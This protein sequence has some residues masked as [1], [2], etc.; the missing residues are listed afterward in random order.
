MSRFYAPHEKVHV[1]RKEIYING[2][3][4]HHII[5]VMRLKKDDKVIVFDG[6]GCEYEGSIKRIDNHDK[7]V[8]VNIANIRKP[9][10]D[11]KTTFHLAQAIPKKNRMDYVVEKATE[12]GVDQII[13]V[14]SDR[15]VV[16]PDKSS[17]AKKVT[18][19]QK[20]A[21][22]TAKQCGRS[23]IPQISGIT[24]YSDIVGIIDNY[25]LVLLACL[26]EDTIPLKKALKGFKDGKV[27]ALIGPEGDFT[28]EEIE[29]AKAKK[30]KF[31]SLGKRILKSDTAGL[32]VASVLGYETDSGK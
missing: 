29:K 19:W 3:E 1:G 7:L 16:R 17:A 6:T 27:I 31:I 28:P 15:T 26:A 20:I 13:P 32:Y 5:D 14:V 9:A 21:E 10:V 30:C 23:D 12:L 2:E 11:N 22:Q 18:R 24:G 8:V 25:D 4:A